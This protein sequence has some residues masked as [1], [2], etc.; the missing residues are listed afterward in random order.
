MTIDIIFCKIKGSLDNTFLED[1]MR[2]YVVKKI[3]SNNVLLVGEN[4][5]EY[6]LVGKGVG[7]AKKKDMILEDLENVE[8]TFIS[9]SGLDKYQYEDLLSKVDEKI[10]AITE[11]IIGMASKELGE[12]LNPHIHTGLID[13]VNFAIKRLEEGIEIVNPFLMETK[14]MYPKE[15]SIAEKSV[16]LLKE[17]LN[18]KIPDAE[19]GFIAF[20]IHGGRSDKSK[21]SALKNTKLVNQ[22]VRYMENKLEIRLKENSLDY[23]RFIAHLMGVIDRV[24]NKKY[25]KNILLPK[26]KEEFG[27]E[28][29]IAYDISKMIE[30]ELNVKVP[31]DEIGYIMLHLYKLNNLKDR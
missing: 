19:I 28:Y 30:K 1:T 8:N 11:E 10:V 22:V 6:I 13:H 24:E 20:H 7:F 5:K 25:L 9:L 4:E 14:I 3:L 18:I 23:T 26:L 31:E 16:N 12:T 29:K 2:K 17:R 27:F 15:F 21:A